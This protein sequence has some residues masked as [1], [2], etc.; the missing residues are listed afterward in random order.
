VHLAENQLP[1]EKA[2]ARAIDRFRETGRLVD[3]N[4]IPSAV[5]APTRTYDAVKEKPEAAIAAGDR[6]LAA[7]LLST[8]AI[9]RPTDPKR[10]P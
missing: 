10:K 7:R 1:I 4:Y 3:P 5:D 2:V 6:W 9:P 8:P